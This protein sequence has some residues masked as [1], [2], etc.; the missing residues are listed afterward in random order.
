M[1]MQLGHFEIDREMTR[2][3][4]AKFDDPEGAV[5]HEAVNALAK[6]GRTNGLIRQELIQ[7]VRSDGSPST[8]VYAVLSIADIGKES[9][10]C[11]PILI[12]FVARSFDVAET[13]GDSLDLSAS[14]GKDDSA[15]D[16]QMLKDRG[17]APMQPDSAFLATVLLDLVISAV[18]EA[19]QEK[20]ETNRVAHRYNQYY[21]DQCKKKFAGYLEKIEA[22]TDAAGTWE[23]KLFKTTIRYRLAAVSYA[24]AKITGQGFGSDQKK[25]REWWEA[26]K[27]KRA[28]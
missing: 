11:I 17:M 4:L 23:H 3:L 2:R 6:L 12:D 18:A 7:A 20:N 24:L 16:F 5:R 8:S 15:I 28:S 9:F 13:F 19:E 27:G 26:N 25:W 10:E 22:M 1:G 21:L 14:Y